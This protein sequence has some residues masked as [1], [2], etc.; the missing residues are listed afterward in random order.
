MGEERLRA[1]QEAERQRI[2]R[3]REEALRIER[4]REE[5]LVQE[6]IQR[7][8]AE[9]ER[10]RQEKLR[11]ER[12]EAERKEC[13]RIAAE[14]EKERLKRAEESRIAQEKIAKE[15][16]EQGEADARVQT[17][18]KTNGF[19]GVTEK[20]TKMCSSSYPLHTAVAQNSADVVKDLLRCG[21][22][23]KQKNSAGQTAFALAEKCNKKGKHDAVVEVLKN[24]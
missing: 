17:F 15:Q 8:R 12:E 9:A 5:R 6:K 24:A 11:L 14:Q 10:Q 2:E 13:E 18:L 20:R 4:E 21:A 22:D 16:R 7:E 3:E 19:K 23:A 1:E